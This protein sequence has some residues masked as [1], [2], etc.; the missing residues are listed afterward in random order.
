MTDR[1]ADKQIA[2][3]IEFAV[4]R[5]DEL[6]VFPSVAEHLINS[7]N[8]FQLS[9]SV[10]AELIETEPA[11]TTMLFSLA[12]QR[13][14]RLKNGNFDIHQTLEQLPL[15]L[16]RDKLLTSK[17][18]KV[19]EQRLN[20]R[21]QLLRHCVAVGCCA[22]SIAK[23]LEPKQD[24]KPFYYAGL[25]H[26]IG[27][28]AL[29]E[30]MPR[31]FDRIFEQAQKVQCAI[32]DTEK[33][34]LGTDHTI[35]GKHLAERWGLPQQLIG[36]VWL[37]H[38]NM[39]GIEDMPEAKIAA[40]VQA[41]DIICRQ[42]GIGTSGSFDSPSLSTELLNLLGINNTQIQQIRQELAEQVEKKCKSSGLDEQ[43][44]IKNFQNTIQTGVAQLAEE[45]EKLSDDNYRL[46]IDSFNL[47][48]LNEFLSGIKPDAD[49]ITIAHTFAICWQ[50]FYQTGLIC[51]YLIPP[52]QVKRL[53]SVIVQS[54]SQVK[55]TLLKAP[56]STLLIPKSI[57]GGFEVIDAYEGFDWLFEQLDLEFDLSRTIAMPIVSQD[58]VLAVM[59]FE[60]RHPAKKDQ[61]QDRFK[62]L[63]NLVGKIFALSCEKQIQQLYAERFSQLIS[64]MVSLPNPQPVTK[65]ITEQQVSTGEV[66]ESLQAGSL[67]ALAE[68]AAGAAHELN[69]PLLVISGRAQ[70]LAENE[71][72]DSKKKILEQIQ[73]NAGQISKIVDELLSFAKPQRPEPKKTNIKQLLDQAVQLAAQKAN[74]DAENVSIEINKNRGYVYVDSSQIVNS[75]ANIIC[76]S[77]ESYIT[78]SG[79]ISITAGPDGTGRAVAVTISDLGC[80]MDSA[81]V[82][83][84][85]FP[86]FSAKPAGRKRGLGLAV[87]SRLIKLNNGQISIESIPLEGTKITVTLPSD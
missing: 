26:D 51:L 1:P 86:F 15:R 62:T 58:K 5:L 9:P 65:I 53:E 3:E 47:K 12:H 21:R 30:V 69:N 22:E 27:K 87:A 73:K 43:V 36:A 33:K 66:S 49:T 14:I 83:K 52:E 28:L 57:A 78:K 41:A 23:I 67:D 71:K 85:T 25:L 46:Q 16:I 70:L 7:I 64:S 82:Q 13:D 50:Q 18:Y 77:F 8:K 10:L 34:Y 17:I 38:S 35:L 42:A 32:R 59:V 84:A 61:L 79:P 44:T 75:L 20:L 74:A 37:H 60:L 48:F 76:N 80:G 4:C 19:D 31:S 63:I 45:N 54:R 56:P 6:A 11:L 39:A 81:T 24:S 40:C 2:Q 29:D 68:M 72:D 55:T